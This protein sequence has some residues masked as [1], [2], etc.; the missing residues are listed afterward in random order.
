MRPFWGILIEEILN[1][2]P[3]IE[4]AAVEYA[5]CMSEANC[6]VKGCIVY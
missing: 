4:H 1:H 2:K 3:Q 6:G 5:V